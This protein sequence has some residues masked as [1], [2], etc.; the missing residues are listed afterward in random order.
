MSSDP[1]ATRL[2][3]VARALVVDAWT[4]EASAAL[5][6]AGVPA[7]LLK[8]PVIARWLYDPPEERGYGDVDLL[9][10]PRA[11]PAAERILDGLGY[12]LKDP[13]GE[14]ELVS[15]PHAQTWLRPRDGAVIDLHH[16]LPGDVLAGELVWAELWR[17]AETMD[18]DNHH[19]RVLDEPSRALMVALHAAH[20]G[21]ETAAP[22]EDLR[23]AAVQAPMSTW[24]QAADIASAILALPKFAE[25][26]QLTP[27]GERVARDLRLASPDV[28]RSLDSTQLAS[29]FER[30]A[31]T[32][33]LASRAQLIAGE[34]VPSPEF[35]RWWMPL[36][37]R[38][39]RGLA[40]A[41]VYRFAWLLVQA[42]GGW[43]A[44]RRTRA[45][46]P[47]A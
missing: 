41:Y 38:S 21:G 44:W 12:E 23:R 29:G 34:L 7:L 22:L 32:P 26:L 10:A 43:R 2:L 15:G 40:A 31:A 5:E 18:I 6:R 28:L 20:H 3:V 17:R 33:G 47:P 13:E 30:L 37:R 8:G 35:M 36:A 25:G 19:V 39:R 9:V 4:V 46:E 27:E 11:I 14:L 42:A 16:T 45:Q 1:A 24:R